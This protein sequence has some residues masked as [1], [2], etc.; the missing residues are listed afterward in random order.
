M[1]QSKLSLAWSIYSEAGNQS[2]CA[3]FSRIL[4]RAEA[5]DLVGIGTKFSIE[6]HSIKEITW[7]KLGPYT[8]VWLVFSKKEA[9]VLKQ[10]V[11]YTRAPLH[12]FRGSFLLKHLKKHGYH[13]LMSHDSKLAIF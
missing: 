3:L 6:N 8:E 13:E 2:S 10:K 5:I 1:N 7:R 9:H 12:T 11:Y 4:I